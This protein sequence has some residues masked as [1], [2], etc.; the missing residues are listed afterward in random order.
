MH[1]D[2]DYDIPE[3][4]QLQAVH[5]KAKPSPPPLPFIPRPPLSPIRLGPQSQRE[6]KKLR[7]RGPKPSLG[8]AVLLGYLGPNYPDVARKGAEISLDPGSDFESS[9]G[10]EMEDRPGSRSR[11]DSTMKPAS[12]DPKVDIARKV[13]QLL[14]AQTIEDG[15]G[16]DGELR[17]PKSQQ[18]KLSPS[19]PLDIVNLQISALEPDGSEAR[20]PDTSGSAMVVDGPS[21]NGHPVPSDSLA[22]SPQLREHTIPDSEGPATEK[23]PALYSPHPSS[24]EAGPG[25]PNQIRPL[26]AFSEL[27]KLA[28]AASHD[29]DS[30][31]NGF[32]HRQSISS[33]NGMIPVP[34]QTNQIR[35]L[36]SYPQANN[37]LSSPKSRPSVPTARPQRAMGGNISP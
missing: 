14:H 20:R 33:A 9:D 7:G 2:P 8:D 19:A 27:N 37:Y 18:G 15:S 24:N 5:V 17:S 1:Y 26:P 10:G 12:P 4:P 35:E 34:A 23:L 28:E 30:R 13:T 31:S 16:A 32:P 21:P 29:Q 22:T 3:S 11:Q 25:S 36:I 6:R